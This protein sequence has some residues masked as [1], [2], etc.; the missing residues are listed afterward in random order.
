MQEDKAFKTNDIRGIYPKEINES[1]A[2]LIGKAIVYKFK[3]KVVVIGRDARASSPLLFSSVVKG[4]LESGCD[5]IDIGLTNTPLFYYSVGELKADFGIMITASHNPGQYNGF[6]LV[7]KGVVPTTAKEIQDIKNII[8]E[9]KATSSKPKKLGKIIR[10]E[11]SEKY[12]KKL[13][14]YSKIKKK[15]KVVV[16][17]G[18]GMAAPI[19][20]KAFSNLPISVIY[21]NKK[22][23]MIKPKHEANPLK[24][25][26]LKELQKEV[27]KNKADIGIAFDGDGDRV[28]F[29]DDNGEIIPMDFITALLA[30]YFLE[31]KP[32][33]KII[34]DIRSSNIVKETVLASVGIPV[35]YKVGHSLIK[36]KMREIN[37]VFAGEISGHYYLPEFYYC[38]APIF[39]SII[40]MNY[41]EREK[42]SK[43]ILP[44]RKYYKSPEINYKIKNPEKKIKELRNKYSSGKIKTL[45]GLKIEYSDWWFNVRGSHTEPLLRL[46]LEANTKEL[47]VKKLKEIEDIIKK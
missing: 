44:F 26:T 42:L 30:K 13:L 47:M 21:I 40:L 29:V 7:K 37:A 34:Y 36:K 3:P 15:L 22:M 23:D 32:K 4:V 2:Y 39:I 19:V 45:D 27:K 28:G 17:T 46:N 24:I 12:L 20:S 33:S 9:K 14:S 1:L 18:N 35:E 10:K 38:E 25:E 41:L 6:K 16:D 43:M 11:I 5:V 31:K 8:L